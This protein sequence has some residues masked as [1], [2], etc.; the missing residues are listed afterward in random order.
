V[1]SAGGTLTSG[2]SVRGEL[3]AGDAQLGSGEFYDVFTF[4]GT[5]G[6]SAS[7]DM[8]S[9]GAIDPYLVVVFPSGRQAENDDFGPNDRNSRISL[10]LPETGEYRVMCTSYA[11]GET[12][13]YDVGFLLAEGSPVDP[14]P[15]IGTVPNQN[16]GFFGVFVG[17]SDY[18]GTH[19]DLP[20]CREDAEKLAATFGS[21]GLMDSSNVEVFTD[22]RAS[23]QNV[24]AALARMASRVGPDDVFVFFYSGHG[25][26]SSPNAGAH[27]DEVD[28]R[29][30][31]IILGNDE[32]T[33]DEMARD[34]D[35]IHAGLTV[36]ALDSCFSGGFAR[37]VVSRPNRVGLF[38]SE[39]D[40][41]SAV[42]GEFQAGGYLS[43]FFQKAIE[44]YADLDGDGLI[45]VGEL[46]HYLQDQYAQ[47]V[48]NVGAH[49]ADGASGYQHLVVD[50]GAVRVDTL[51]FRRGAAAGAGGR[52]IEL[53]F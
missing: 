11:P 51:F 25:S 16:R 4:Q 45:R 29:V 34:L 48:R 19:N 23:A 6:Q 10:A 43:H 14:G 15:S 47:H 37:D 44:G 35:G 1:P 50:R 49:S 12:G 3:A 39:E 13:A 32:Y 26:Q 46:S 9:A 2:R 30:E 27:P 31:S 28:G 18:P 20:L 7:I 24:R 17:I 8:V 5:S 41:T 38:S 22:G 52:V 33:D 36:V 21:V 42:A 53:G 40:L